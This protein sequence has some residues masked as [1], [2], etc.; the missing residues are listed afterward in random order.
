MKGIVLGVKELPKANAVGRSD[1]YPKTPEFTAKLLYEHVVRTHAPLERFFPNNMN[2]AR[3]KQIDRS[4]LH[5]V[6]AFKLP[7]F[8]NIL[9]RKL[10]TFKINRSRKRNAVNQNGG[11]GDA[12]IINALGIDVGNIHRL[13]RRALAL[14]AE[15]PGANPAYQRTNI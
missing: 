6:L 14:I 1:K 5:E 4:Y 12:G 13:N 15:E 2:A 8:M 7:G 3:I 9:L 10:R 11:N